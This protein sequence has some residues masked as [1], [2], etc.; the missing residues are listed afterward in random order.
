MIKRIVSTVVML[1]MAGSALADTPINPF[2]QT[3]RTIMV[4]ID[5]D[6]ANFGSVGQSFGAKLSANWTSNGSVGFI[7]VPGSSVENLVSNVFSGVSAVPG[8]FTDYQIQIDLTNGHVI[9]ADLSG[10]LVLPLIGA[11]AVIQ[12]ATSAEVAGFKL[13]DLFGIIYP[14]HCTSGADCTIVPGAS[15]DIATGQVNAVGKIATLVQVFSPFGDMRFTELPAAPFCDVE[16]TQ[17]AYVD[18]EVTGLSI[19]RFANLGGADIVSRLLV[20]LKYDATAFTGTAFDAGADSS[21]VL[22][23]GWDIDYGPQ[24]ILPVQ[25]ALPRGTWAYRCAIVDPVSGAV[26]AEDTAEFE[27]Q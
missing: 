3:S 2:N 25:A 1:C 23:T 16:T 4:Q 24:A 26:Y 20:E 14:Q 9:A 22:P 12:T 13:T 10:Q 6:F 8:S 21:L 27:I 5:E 11:Q 18:G 7:T 19:L 17:S 15:Y